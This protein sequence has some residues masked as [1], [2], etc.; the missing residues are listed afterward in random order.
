MICQTLEE[1]LIL[2]DLT[3]QEY[4]GL[5]PVGASMWKTLMEYPEVNEAC[6]RMSTLYDATP[7]RIK[8]DM[9]VLVEALLAKGL[10][11]ARHA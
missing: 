5:N 8:Q 3:T 2:L 10:L 11:K 6:A 9:E 7:A 1:E 4:F